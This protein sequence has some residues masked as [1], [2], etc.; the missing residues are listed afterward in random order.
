M[1]SP[2]SLEDHR[3]ILVLFDGVCNLCNGIVQFIIKRDPKAKFRFASLQ[4]EFGKSQLIQ[5][6]LNPELLHSLIVID[7][8]KALERS[9]AALH[10]AKHL[11]TPWKLLTVF[12]I[13]PK[14]FRDACYNLV[15]SNRYRIFGKL[16]SCMIPTPEL[17]DRFIE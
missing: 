5:F 10:I 7:N 1:G 2:G 12:K 15:A 14:F 17:K 4:S 9:D 13:L 6:K 11:G 16:A 8:D 3:P